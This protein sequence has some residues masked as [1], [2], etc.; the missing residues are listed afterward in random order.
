METSTAYKEHLSIMKELDLH[1]DFAKVREP[2]KEGFEKIYAEAIEADVKVSNAKAFLEDLKIEELSTLQEYTRLADEVVVDELSDEGAYNLLMHFYEK[3]D[4]DGDGITEDG[5]ARTLSY[6]PQNMDSDL[7]KA[8]VNAINSTD[9]DNML[10]MM[11]LT[12][13]IDRLKYDLAQ[14]VDAM[15]D[16]EKS[17][18][19]EHASFDIDLFIEEQLQE[20]FH[21][22]PISF[23]DIM[24]RIDNILDPG[25]GA[26]SSP[27]LQEGMQIF[28]DTL[29]S[30]YAQVKEAKTQGLQHQVSS[31][32]L[33]QRD[34]SQELSSHD[35][36]ALLLQES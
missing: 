23:D 33:L 17:Y 3:Y 28:S 16:A 9:E 18:M 20:P 34:E 36:L 7:K 21:P 1:S 26:Y 27:E 35:P 8:F 6:I 31:N 2:Y 15:S 5:K 13:N 19:R 11:M 14:Q 12:F 22:K 29:Q 10:S 4:F 30:E 32:D 25:P 24:A